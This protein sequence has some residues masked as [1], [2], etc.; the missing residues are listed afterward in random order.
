[1]ESTILLYLKGNTQSR[2]ELEQ[3]LTTS[4]SENFWDIIL[5]ELE[6]CV[7]WHD[8]D[9]VQC[10]LILISRRLLSHQESADYIP[11]SS[12]PILVERLLTIRHLIYPHSIIESL[13]TLLALVT[14]QSLEKME[15]IIRYI[16]DTL[17]TENSI[18]LLIKYYTEL[19]IKSSYYQQQNNDNNCSNILKNYFPKLLNCLCDILNTNKSTPSSGN[20]TNDQLISSSITCLRMWINHQLISYL[21]LLNTNPFYLIQTLVFYTRPDQAYSS[22]LLALADFYDDILTALSE[23]NNGNTI[24]SGRTIS[25]QTGDHTAI[26]NGLDEISSLETTPTTAAVAVSLSPMNHECLIQSLAQYSEIFQSLLTEGYAHGPHTSTERVTYEHSYI[27]ILAAAIKL[28][29]HFTGN[30]FLFKDE[31]N[32]RNCTDYGILNVLQQLSLACS[33]RNLSYAVI[34]MEVCPYESHHRHHHGLSL[35]N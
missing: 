34:A 18:L 13:S 29:Y 19:A 25:I 8:P 21:D 3:F 32:N 5:I 24:P 16:D 27:R 2:H 1:M 22:T 15:E 30:P 26:T 10:L 35:G 14:L 4:S 17:L 11:S 33:H 31:F 23:S 6:N 7:K 9:S 20:G 12:I 28:L